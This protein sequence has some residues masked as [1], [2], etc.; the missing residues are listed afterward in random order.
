MT[1]KDAAR[2]AIAVAL[3]YELGVDAAPRVTAKGRGEV[4]ARIVAAAKD[5][6]VHIERNE[7]L[8]QSLSQLEIDQHIPKELYKAVAEVI[9]FVLRCGANAGGSAKK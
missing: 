6:G 5:A 3:H 8:A 9:R 1:E 7:A 2:E 4:A